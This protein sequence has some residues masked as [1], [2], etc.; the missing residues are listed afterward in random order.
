MAELQ[1]TG[2][3]GPAHPMGLRRSV[4]ISTGTAGGGESTNLA[5]DRSEVLRRLR[6]LVMEWNRSLPANRLLPVR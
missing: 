5:A 3:A 2:G 1:R 4:V 6:G